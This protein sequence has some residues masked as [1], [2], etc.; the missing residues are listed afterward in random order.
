[1]QKTERTGKRQNKN[2]NGTIADRGIKK[3]KEEDPKLRA[4]RV[5]NYLE[6]EG[7]QQGIRPWWGNPG[8]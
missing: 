7:A 4:S 5:R 8:P 6:D 1:M 2:K 3:G